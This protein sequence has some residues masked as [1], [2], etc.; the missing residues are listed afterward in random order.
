M[1]TIVTTDRAPG[2]IQAVYAVFPSSIRIRCWFHRLSNIRAKL[3]DE[4]APEVMAHLY[5]VRDAPTLDATRVVADRFE[6][7]FSRE[8]P[9]AVACFAD[10]RE[11]LLSIHRV[12]VR[13]ASA[14]GR[15]TSPN[16]ASK[17]NAGA[18]RSSRGS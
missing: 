8:F 15:P 6:N 13:R 2:M 17:K 16:G 10:D 18:P 7:T 1:P 4:P 11:A 12:P 9:S 14:S 5:A 3:P